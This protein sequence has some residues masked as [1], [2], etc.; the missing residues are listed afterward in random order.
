MRRRGISGGIPGLTVLFPSTCREILI[1]AQ[2]DLPGIVPLPIEG[3]NRHGALSIMNKVLVISE[4]ETAASFFGMI[5]ELEYFVPVL[6][7]SH[8][9]AVQAIRRLNPDV[10]I[11]DLPLADTCA[12]ELCVQLRISTIDKPMIV[13]GDSSE[14]IDK[15]LALE[16]GADYYMVKPVAPRELVARVRALLRRRR[17]DLDPVIH[18]G[19]VEVDRR[20][21]TVTC[22]GQQIEMTPCEYKLLLFF[23]ANVDL[24]LTRQTLLRSVWGYSDDAETRTLDAHVSQLRK[25]CEPDPSIPRHFL[26]VHGVGYRFLA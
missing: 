18:F 22:R 4:N 3:E 8:D 2:K 5:L 15:V 25:K 23:L 10:L 20:R 9:T 12:A 21:R 26:T 11:I 24:A 17:D 1:P 14:E 19:N 13:L 16:A 6:A 7:N